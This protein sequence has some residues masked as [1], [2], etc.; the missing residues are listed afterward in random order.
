[1][2]GCGVRGDSDKEWEKTEEKK[3]A[4]TESEIRNIFSEIIPIYSYRP[5]LWLVYGRRH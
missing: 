1:M 3:T 4:D 2:S 5:K